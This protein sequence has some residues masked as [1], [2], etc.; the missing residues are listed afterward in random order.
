M[1]IAEMITDYVNVCRLFDQH[2]EAIEGGLLIHPVDKDPRAETERW[3]ARLKKHRYE[4]ETILIELG[5]MI[6]QEPDLQ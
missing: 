2:I 3:L 1:T 4:Y 6:R 5:G